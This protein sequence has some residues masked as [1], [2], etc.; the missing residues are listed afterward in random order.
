[1]P[2]KI[3]RMLLHL[4][5]NNKKVS[6]YSLAAML[7]PRTGAPSW[8]VNA[9]KTHA[10]YSE[11]Q[12]GELTVGWSDT[13]NT[14]AEIRALLNS[15]N[16]NKGK[17]DHLAGSRMWVLRAK[18]DGEV[19]MARPCKRCISILKKFGVSRI[20]YTNDQ[21]EAEEIRI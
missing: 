14:H 6:K 8:G 2:K 4:A 18:K 12:V 1:M 10:A 19:G 15:I 5:L 3:R 7:K 13:S 16:M 21:G 17:T 20:A 11:L 9:A